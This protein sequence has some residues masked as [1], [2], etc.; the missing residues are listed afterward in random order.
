MKKYISLDTI[1][2]AAEHRLSLGHDKFATATKDILS[3]SSNTDLYYHSVCHSKFCAVKRKT[4]EDTSGSIQ[5]L[6]LKVTVSNSDLPSSSSTGTLQEQCIFCPDQRKRLKVF[7]RYE[8]LCRLES[9]DCRDEI[10]AAAKQ[11]PDL[12]ASQKIL[13]LGLKD[14]VATEAKYHNSCKKKFLRQ[15]DNTVIEPEKSAR[16]RHEESFA[17]LSCFI[18]NEIIS[19]RN[20]VYASKLMDLYKEEYMVTGTY[21]ECIKSYK[22]QMLINK[23]KKKFGDRLIVSNDSKKGGNFLYP[24]E[25]TFHEAKECLNNSTQ[26]NKAVRYAAMA[27]RSEIL[28][29][30]KTKWPTPTSIDTVK[31]NS[32]HIPPLT[33]LFC[34][35]LLNGLGSDED[36]SDTVQ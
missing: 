23:I 9:G 24:K 20:P 27:L 5:S 1:R 14:L 28:N 32:P 4:F 22:S 12:E 36:I 34:E 17:V 26:Q 3:A 2:S 15:T 30:A 29:M 8:K 33:K 7:G 13:A 21:D 6:P 35:T 11:K 19:K 16:K 10:L 31:E 25:M 18:E